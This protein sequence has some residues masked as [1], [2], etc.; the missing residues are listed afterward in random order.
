M[1]RLEQELVSL[2]GAGTV[3]AAPA[4]LT[5]VRHQVA[6][7]KVREAIG[8]ALETMEARGTLDCVAV[9]LWDAW[10][11]MGEILGEAMSEEIIDAI[12]QEFCIGK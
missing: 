3:A 8:S 2:V 4:M 12:F 6:L 7:Q 5:R 11:A 1:Q 10:S 9:D